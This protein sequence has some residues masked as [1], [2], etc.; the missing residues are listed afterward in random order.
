MNVADVPQFTV[1][2]GG[3][4]VPLPPL[5]VAV[6][7]N[8]SIANVAVT[9]QS[10]RILPVCHVVLVCCVSVHVSPTTLTTWYPASGVT[11]TVAGVPG[12]MDCDGGVAVPC[13]PLT[14]AETVYVDAQPGNLNEPICVSHAVVL[15]CATVA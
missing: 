7:V 9:A 11:V 15:E 12:S 5:T 14:L 10:A 2:D 6:T 3:A 4:I 8:V 1:C 13:P